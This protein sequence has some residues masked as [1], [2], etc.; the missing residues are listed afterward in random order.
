[1]EYSYEICET[2]SYTRIVKIPRIGTD[3][4]EQTPQTQIR[5]QG[6]KFFFMLNS[7]EHEVLDAYKYITIKKFGFFMLR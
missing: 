6:Y 1:M 3:R 4:S 5:P 7:V 2:N